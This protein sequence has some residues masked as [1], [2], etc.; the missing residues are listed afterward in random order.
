MRRARLLA[1]LALRN[2][3][4]QTRRSILTASAMVLG[5]A[6]LVFSRALG[7]G[8]HEDWI[9]Q[10]VRLGKG[11]IAVQHPRFQQ[12]RHLDDRLTPRALA[13]AERALARPDIAKRV[14][15]V[16]PRLEIQGLAYSA[17]GPFR[18]S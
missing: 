8:A 10:G 14:T 6:V 4:R 12:S 9:D 18:Y 15:A 3:R 2:V 1:R 17:T 16:A 13:V 7:D 11:H 5:V